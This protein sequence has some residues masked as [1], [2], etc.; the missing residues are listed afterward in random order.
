MVSRTYTFALS[1]KPAHV[2][3]PLALDEAD[4]LRNRVF[5]R[6]RK[7]HMDV[8]GHQ[9]PFLD[10][11]LLLMSGCSRWNFAG[12]PAKPGVSRLR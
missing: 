7:Q 11:R 10:I 2:N 4:H 8:I 12:G 9:M 6:D 3:R 1:I 5:R